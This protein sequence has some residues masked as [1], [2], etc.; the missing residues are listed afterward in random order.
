[1]PGFYNSIHDTNEV[2]LNWNGFLLFIFRALVAKE[3]TIRCS[4]CER[5]L[6]NYFWQK[7]KKKG[8]KMV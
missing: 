7:I 4:T 5:Y 2:V 3:R 8:A 6:E 1:M